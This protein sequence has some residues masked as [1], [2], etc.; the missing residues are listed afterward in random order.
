MDVVEQHLLEESPAGLHKELCYGIADQIEIVQ[1]CMGI[2]PFL[3]KVIVVFESI[4]YRFPEQRPALENAEMGKSARSFGAF[5]PEGGGKTFKKI[6]IS[7]VEEGKKWFVAG[8][9][10]PLPADVEAHKGIVPEV[11]R[12]DARFVVMTGQQ[13]VQA[14]P[15]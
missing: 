9:H 8:A 1:V 15:Q 11:S 6:R 12:D 7:D 13:L 10:P 4:V 3:G 14:C 2:D 5:Y